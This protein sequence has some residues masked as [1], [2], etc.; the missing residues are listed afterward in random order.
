MMNRYEMIYII[1]AD[2][3]E[4]ARKERTTVVR[5]KRSMKRG[6]SASWLT[7]STTRPKAGTYW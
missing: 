1:D 6:E 2:L 5:S 7:R 3:E 4:T